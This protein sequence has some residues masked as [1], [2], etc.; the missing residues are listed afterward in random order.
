MEAHFRKRITLGVLSIAGSV[1]AFGVLLYWMSG[2]LDS[3]TAKIV[4]ARNAIEQQ[5]QLVASLAALKT[6]K[7]EVEKYRQALDA[8]LPVK[9][10]LVNF[11]SWIDGLS[12]A[13]QAGATVAFK[14]KA[15][16][17]A[18]NQAGSI[19]FSLDAQGIYGDLVDF[20][21]DVEFKGPR[22]LVTLDNISIKRSGSA[23]HASV[24]G[25]VFF[26]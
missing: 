13:H 5:A 3:Q 9:D 21:K 26:R 15:V 16:P 20:L 23:Y 14:G 2:V 7:P 1:A 12:R 25:T 18:E 19:G 6:A 10:D 17:A 24:N 8:L 22:Y 11:P 4:A